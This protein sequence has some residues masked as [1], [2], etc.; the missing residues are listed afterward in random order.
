MELTESLSATYLSISFD[1]QLKTFKNP[2]QKASSTI[3]IEGYDKYD[4]DLVDLSGLGVFVLVVALIGLGKNPYMLDF[5]QTLFLMALV[6]VHYPGNL[7][8]FLEGTSIA[9]FHGWIG[10]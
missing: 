10:L 4:D 2:L 9:H 1:E 5:A 3:Y 8:S 6:D 7:A